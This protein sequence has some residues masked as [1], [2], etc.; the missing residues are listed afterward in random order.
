MS[1]STLLGK[2]HP[3]QQKK[4]PEVVIPLFREPEREVP[5]EKRI[6]IKLRSTPDDA[7]SQ[8]YE[9]VTRAFDHGT[10]EEWIRHRKMITKVLDG[11]NITNGPD[12][13]RMTRRL[14]E[15]KALADFEASIV[16]NSYIE[17]VPHLKKALKDVAI[18]IFPTRALQ[19][20]KR[21]MRRRMPKP[22]GMPVAQYWARLVELNQYLPFFPGG[23]ENSK[24]A[25]DDLKEVLEFGIPETWRMYMTITRFIPANET[26]VKIVNFCRELEGIESE[27]GSLDV[28]GISKKSTRRSPVSKKP[29]PPV[30]QPRRSFKKRSRD[31]FEGLDKS[32][33]C[34][35][36][37][38]L[39]HTM[40]QCEKLKSLI[41]AERSNYSKRSKTK[42]VSFKK[43]SKSQEELNV[44][45][46]DYLSSRI[47][48][49]SVKPIVKRSM[50]WTKP[51]VCC[52]VPKKNN[53]DPDEPAY[54][55]S[56]YPPDA[57]VKAKSKPNSKAQ[58]DSKIVETELQQFNEFTLH[59][60]ASPEEQEYQKQVTSSDSDAEAT[61][62]DVNNSNK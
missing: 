48:P 38:N 57:P 7:S 56:A 2:I 17:S 40:G 55:P 43:N 10:P 41:E 1:L 9:V 54:S 5:K 12:S 16:T 28:I 22:F 34:P 35:I 33:P 6:V 31:K 25:D 44:M 50:K 21:S 52:E 23:D 62:V 58:F 47:L 19:K 51:R 61:E 14:L 8:L 15:G 46:E 49:R 36:H 37:P 24:L 30:A 53:W 60:K 4:K 29:D 42:T 11:Q 3:P 32:G 27:H 39:P 26:P 20:Q 18:S 59:E 45:I 13:F